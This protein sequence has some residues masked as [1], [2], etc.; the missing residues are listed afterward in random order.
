MLYTLMTKV[1]RGLLRRGL[2]K[3][4]STKHNIV[5]EAEIVGVSDG[6]GANLGLTYQ[7]QDQ[8]Y[9]IKPV[10]LY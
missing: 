8:G 1:E 4:S 3:N 5:T 6:L 9:D 7:L 2:V 10:I